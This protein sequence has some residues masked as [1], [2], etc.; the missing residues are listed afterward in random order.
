MF[1]DIVS[2]AKTKNLQPIKH[3]R[4]GKIQAYINLSD[5]GEYQN[6]LVVD[7]KNQQNKLLPDFGS[8][9]AQGNYAN[10]L[11]ER[12]SVILNYN[13]SEE[14]KKRNKK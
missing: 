13:K 6:I 4:T 1:Q 12:L 2:F 14:K 8:L 3:R 5:D 10:A 11:V 7:K 9:A